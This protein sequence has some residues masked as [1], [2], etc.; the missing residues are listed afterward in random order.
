MQLFE[1]IREYTKCFGSL[2]VVTLIGM[3]CKGSFAE[4]RTHVGRCD[5][6]RGLNFSETEHGEGVRCSQDR[7]DGGGHDVQRPVPAFL[8]PISVSIV[9]RLKQSPKQQKTSPRRYTRGSGVDRLE[10]VWV[11]ACAYGITR[12]RC[13]N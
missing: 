10:A 12:P 6:T 8:R 13:N 1:R 11:C 7:L 5:R 2:R 9:K 3:N 4:G